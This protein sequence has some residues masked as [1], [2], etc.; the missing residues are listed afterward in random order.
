MA[1]EIYGTCEFIKTFK[2]F[3]NCEWKIK[4][5]LPELPVGEIGENLCKFIEKYETH[6]CKDDISAAKNCFYGIVL[7]KIKK[8]EEDLEELEFRRKIIS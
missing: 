2:H 4:G 7:N 6:F 8:L 5:A 1:C 3:A